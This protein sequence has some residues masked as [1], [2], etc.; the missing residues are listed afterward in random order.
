MSWYD[1]MIEGEPVQKKLDE[2][3]NKQL[4]DYTLIDNDYYVETKDGEYTSMY[5][6]SDEYSKRTVICKRLKI[7][8]P[9][10]TYEEWKQ[11]ENWARFTD[12]YHALREQ[13]EIAE[14]E[15]AEL[16]DTI[17]ALKSELKEVCDVLIRKCPEMKEW[18]MLNWRK[19]YD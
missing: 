9:V 14:Y 10:P 12:D 18:V 4:M 5:L 13:K 8:E 19:L 6:G 16:K 15:N 3:Y 17:K 7:L 1:G 2:D 11:L